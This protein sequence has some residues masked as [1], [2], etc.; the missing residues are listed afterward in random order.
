VRAWTWDELLEKQSELESS[1]RKTM[2]TAVKDWGVEVDNIGFVSFV[3][4]RS[5]SLANL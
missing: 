5:F 4:T 3:K 1:A 2:T